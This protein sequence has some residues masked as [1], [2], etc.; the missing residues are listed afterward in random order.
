M[1]LSFALAGALLI[2]LLPTTLAS[3]WELTGD[4][5]CHDPSII[6]EG[7]RWYTFCT[8]DG[9]QVLTSEDGLSWVRA[10]QI[11]LSALSWWTKYVPSFTGMSVWAPD[12]NVFNNRVYLFY[13][14]STFGSQTSAIGLAT[15][16][17]I[18][19]GSWSDQ[20]VI[21][22]S[23][24]SKDYNAIDPNL[25][26]DQSGQPW[27]AFGSFW[28]GLKITKLDPNTM[29]PTGSIYSIAAQ[30]DLDGE[31]EAPNI[32]YHDGYYYLF[33]SIGLCCRG[34]D[35]TYRIIYTRSKSI[36]GPYVDANGVDA[37]DGGGTVL[38]SGNVRWKGPGGQ[39]I[40]DGVIARH[41]YDADDNGTAKLLINDLNWSNGW[42][43]Y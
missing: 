21:L 18:G 16:D 31:I 24:S 39:D 30:P 17:T 25:I 23:D 32:V 3:F 36:T 8:G 14:V 7:S 5:L 29:K 6:K 15:A 27:L 38:D 26:V 37:L 4:I 1:K 42:P 43:T 34:T 40:S 11:F 28:S 35:S 12:V 33:A 2:S 19:A 13:A 20:G 22:T 10:P 41:A 9:I